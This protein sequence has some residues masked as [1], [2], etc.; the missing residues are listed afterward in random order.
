MTKTSAKELDTK[1]TTV[2]AKTAE[3]AVEKVVA[4]KAPVEKVEAKKAP[5]KTTAAKKTAKVATAKKADI[6]KEEI[7]IQFAGFEFS[8][9]ELIEK[10]KA[11]YVAATGKKIIKNVKLYVKPEE[12][13]VYYVVNEKYL[14][15]VAL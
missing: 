14:G 9:S 10:V 8:D 2:T 5:A 13:M 3:K 12:M 15:K 1:K 11:N 4:T 7:F 6:K